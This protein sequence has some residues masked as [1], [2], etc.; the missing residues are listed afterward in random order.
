M[1][2]PL[3]K[4][5]GRALLARLRAGDTGAFEVIV[6][7]YANYLYKVACRYVGTEDASDILQET[8]TKAYASIDRFRGESAIKTWLH[9]IVVNT[10][11]T[12]LRKST[13]RNEKSLDEFLPAFLD[14]GHRANPTAAWHQ[15][16]ETSYQR[17]ETRQLVRHYIGMLPETYRT[18]LVMRD[19][20][21][22]GGIETAR[23]LGI[24]ANAVKIRLHRARQAL[25]ELLDPHMTG[26]QR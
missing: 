19:I 6:N 3:Q 4:T 18:V 23:M 24:S 9:Q 8:F 5:D 17:S 22:F 20:E 14:D 10:C 15:S 11:L 1:N 12:H 2:N 25:R 26:G 13:V 21:G 7:A 16:A